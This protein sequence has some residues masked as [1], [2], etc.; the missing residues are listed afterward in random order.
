MGSAS[1][2]LEAHSQLHPFFLIIPKPY[3]SD[4]V[5]KDLCNLFSLPVKS[6]QVRF[7]VSLSDN[8]LHPSK[9]KEQVI[10]CLLQFLSE[11]ICMLYQSVPTLDKY[12]QVPNKQ[13]YA[14]NRISLLFHSTF[15]QIQNLSLISINAHTMYMHMHIFCQAI[16]LFGKI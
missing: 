11:I 10:Y 4:I 5:S 13:L 1:L 14:F 16:L 12:C 9:I 3:I 6:I 2:V 7:I 8:T 15:S